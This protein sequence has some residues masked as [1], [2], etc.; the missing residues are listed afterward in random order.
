MLVSLW[1]DTLQRTDR[2]GLVRSIVECNI[3]LHYNLQYQASYDDVS[4]CTFSDREAIILL[5]DS[6][7]TMTWD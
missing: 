2:Q 7:L 3:A 5:L 4:I 6:R 1:P